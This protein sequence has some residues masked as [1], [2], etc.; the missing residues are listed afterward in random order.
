MT[1]I[2]VGV[3]YALLCL[4]FV[5]R[6]CAGAKCGRVVQ[7]VG[8]PVAWSWVFFWQIMA[9][10]CYYELGFFFGNRDRGGARNEKTGD[11]Q[12]GTGMLT[13]HAGVDEEGGYTLWGCHPRSEVAPLAEGMRGS[14]F[15]W[16]QSVRCGPATIAPAA[17]APRPS[18]L[19]QF[20][21]CSF[22]QWPCLCS[23]Q[24]QVPASLAGVRAEGLGFWALPRG[25][26]NHMILS[27]G[28]GVYVVF[29]VWVACGGGG[30]F[31][32]P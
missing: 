16:P 1:S 5:V 24:F 30:V 12:S 20:I 23:T 7:S 28:C 6:L 29:H 18:S 9:F 14:G 19:S 3:C 4:G 27:P 17:P 32:K 2:Y 26:T 25:H 31:H 22:G 10:F 21:T 15:L 8:Q 11:G 13:G